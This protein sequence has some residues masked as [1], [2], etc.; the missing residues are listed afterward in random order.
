[1]FSI[2]ALVDHVSIP[3]IVRN[4]C[5]ATTWKK[6][7]SLLLHRDLVNRASWRVVSFA[8]VRLFV[9]AVK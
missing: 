7:L 1:M 8:E 3:H 5:K 4:V 2:I 6:L 9:Y